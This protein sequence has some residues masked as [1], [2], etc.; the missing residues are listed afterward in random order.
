M[1]QFLYPKNIK[2]ALA[3]RLLA[4]PAHSQPIQPGHN[5][6][7]KS[8]GPTKTKPFRLIKPK[9]EQKRKKCGKKIY[10]IIQTMEFL[11]NA[12]F[13]DNRGTQESW[14]SPLP[15][16]TKYVPFLDSQTQGSQVF[17]R[18]AAALSGAFPLIIPTRNG[19]DPKQIA[20]SQRMPTGIG[21]DPKQY[22][23]P[24]PFATQNGSSPQ[25]NTP[26]P[27]SSAA[28]PAPG[29]SPRLSSLLT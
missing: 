16:A 27:H 3:A 28:T 23:P 8:A 21:A 1:V 13:E 26:A 22:V 2:S 4:P 7:E 14:L 20:P 18:S 29:G 6:S 9:K 25:Q 17:T 10:L 15:G 24:P 11:N 19:A 5:H 12:A